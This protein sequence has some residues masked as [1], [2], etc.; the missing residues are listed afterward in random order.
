MRVKVPTPSL[1][2]VLGRSGCLHA[3]TPAEWDVVLR[4]ARA[5]GLAAH[6][7]YVIER[8]C[9]GEAIPAAVNRHL[10]AERMIADK[11][12]RD[13]EREMQRVVEPL[14]LADI[15]VIALKGAAYIVGGL[16]V[17]QGRV[18]DDIDIL[19]PPEH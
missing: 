4:Q 11:L 10:A 16:T 2:D 3:L 18:F 17:A 6:L 9:F 12:A 8:R 19:V 5:S 7:S 14:L 15:P 1:R 13:I